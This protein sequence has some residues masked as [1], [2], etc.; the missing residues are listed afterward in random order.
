MFKAQEGD[1][2]EENGLYSRMT[3]NELK[4]AKQYRADIAEVYKKLAL[5]HMPGAFKEFVPLASSN[6]SMNSS[7]LTKTK[8]ID[9]PVPQPNLSSTVFVKAV[10]DI[11]GVRIEDE[12]GRGRDENYD[13]AAGSQHILNYKSVA[14]LI[15][16]GQVKLV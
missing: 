12:A 1:T 14:N 2:L 5:D 10:E 15:R 16:S 9:P 7:S 13:M 11:N 3:E 6:E 8:K 4:F